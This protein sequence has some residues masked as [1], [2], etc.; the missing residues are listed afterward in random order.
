MQ[1]KMFLSRYGMT[2]VSFPLI[3]KAIFT[4]RGHIP[5]RA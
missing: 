1:E 5:V 3:V 4:W 2:C